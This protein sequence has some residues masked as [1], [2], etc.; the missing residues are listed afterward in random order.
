MPEWSS[1]IRKRLAGLRV[2]PA[3]EASIVE[4]IS[5]HLDDRYAEL[6]AR[7]ASPEAARNAALDELAG[8][9]A[10]RRPEESASPPRA[11]RARL[12]RRGR[13]P[14]LLSGLAKDF[15]YGA[16]RLRLEPAFA[17]VAI[18]SLALGI[19]ANTAI[20]QLLD[21]VRLRSL[22]IAAARGALQRSHRSEAM[23]AAPATSRATGPS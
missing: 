18:L 10:R 20:F 3:R 21:A 2:E 12:R 23:K 4:E 13:R 19:G 7:G 1:E 15:R 6:V 11:R 16:R 14:G 17:L 5:Q 8:P 22:P 9:G